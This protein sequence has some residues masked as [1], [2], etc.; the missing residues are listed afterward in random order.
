MHG[1]I[2]Q[3]H[4]DTQGRIQGCFQGF[5]KLHGHADH[6]WLVFAC[7]SLIMSMLPC[8]YTGFI[9]LYYVIQRCRQP[10]GPLSRSQSLFHRPWTGY[11]R[12]LA[13]TTTTGV[14][15]SDV[16]CT[17]LRRPLTYKGIQLAKRGA[18]CCWCNML[19]EV[20][21]WTL[22]F[23]RYGCQRRVRNS[24]DGLKR[25]ETSKGRPLHS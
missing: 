5:Q 7:I 17:T 10:L 4:T 3:R 1:V 18:I 25:T 14:L 8:S 20:F 9:Q 22:W 23:V 24:E 2:V 11:A 21:S 15:E 12:L 19:L 13:S 6:L 16:F